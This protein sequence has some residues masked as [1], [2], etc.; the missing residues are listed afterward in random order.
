MILEN[1]IS[2]E[3]SIT[4]FW[5]WKES[6]DSLKANI[7]KEDTLVNSALLSEEIDPNISKVFKYNQKEIEEL[8]SL[9]V[10]YNSLF[11]D[12]KWLIKLKDKLVRL[13]QVFSVFRK[14]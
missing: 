10:S 5:L 4:E 1:K 14:S 7:N 3:D 13:N 11:H 9:N 8:L 6:L 2:D 12:V